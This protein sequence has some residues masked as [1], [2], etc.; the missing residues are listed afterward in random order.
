MKIV[1]SL[2]LYYSTCRYISQTPVAGNDHIV[3]SITVTNLGNVDLFNI[4]VTDDMPGVNFCPGSTSYQVSNTMPLV[5]RLLLR[6][7]SFW[8]GA[9]KL[10]CGSVEINS[11]LLTIN[12]GLT[13]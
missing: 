11:C 8:C 4:Y 2:I 7:P 6:L 9:Y 12:E 13:E 5:L 1:L 10:L 3:W